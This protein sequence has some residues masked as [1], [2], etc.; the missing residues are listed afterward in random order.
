MPNVEAIEEAVEKLSAAE[1]ATFRRWFA[2][3]DATA[4]DARIEA[5]TAAGKLNALAEEALIEYRSGLELF[6]GLERFELG[7]ELEHPPVR[8]R[9]LE[10]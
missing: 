7:D 10:L 9:T 1:L 5:D 3:F 8:P 2:E 6:A 4:W